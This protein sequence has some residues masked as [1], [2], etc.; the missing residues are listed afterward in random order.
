VNGKLIAWTE[1]EFY[2]YAE[3]LCEKLHRGDLNTERFI[4]LA[5]KLEDWR[6]RFDDL[7]F[8]EVGE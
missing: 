2:R 3:I 8:A 7:I 1:S 6:D 5:Y 4:K